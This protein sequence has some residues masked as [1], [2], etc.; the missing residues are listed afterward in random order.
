MLRI[1]SFLDFGEEKKICLCKMICLKFGQEDLS[2]S[3]GAFYCS[4]NKKYP[5]NFQ[6]LASIHLR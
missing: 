4:V 1:E 3:H 2:L 6:L 5:S